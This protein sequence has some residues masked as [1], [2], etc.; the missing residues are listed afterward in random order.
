MRFVEKNTGFRSDTSYLQRAGFWLP[1]ERRDTILN[2]ACLLKKGSDI[3][4]D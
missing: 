2:S 4:R 3:L 1:P